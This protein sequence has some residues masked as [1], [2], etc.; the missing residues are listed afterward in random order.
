[1]G[2]GASAIAPPAPASTIPALNL[3]ALA[4]E[5][6]A[7]TG[8]AVNFE[9]RA[10][11]FEHGRDVSDPEVLVEIARAHGLPAPPTGALEAV[12]S[13][14]EEGLERGVI[15]SPHFFSRGA[16]YFCPALDIG[17]DDAGGLTARFDPV[18]LANFLDHV[19][20]VT[21]GDPE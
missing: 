4:Y 3:S 17:H 19:H 7:A 21:Q 16:D 13:D 20:P 5:R 2:T 15:G 1:M 18:G 9:I 6:D 12:R 10:A 8:V 11:L 14:Y